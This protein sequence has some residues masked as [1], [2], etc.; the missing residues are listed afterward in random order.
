MEAIE[1]QNVRLVNAPL[2]IVYD[3]KDL[4]EEEFE[5]EFHSLNEANDDPIGQWLK[6]A[7]ARGETKDSDPLLLNLLVELHRK[8]D[9]LERTIKD[10]APAR[11]S[12]I[13]EALIEQIGYEHIQMKEPELEI[14][15]L[16]YGRIDLPVHP[17]RDVAIFFTAIN[18][19]L[20][21]ITKIHDRDTKEWNTY[22]TSR[23]RVMI[24]EM[25]GKND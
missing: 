19:K 5:R 9:S 3:H 24:R 15:V 1:D 10:E 25:R 20:A 18:E 17:R 4:N 11:V 13:N 14:G 16:Y 21:K 2:S 8:L 7:K 22:F 12:L 23:E 6:V